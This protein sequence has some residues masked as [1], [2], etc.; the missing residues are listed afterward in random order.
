MGPHGP[1]DDMPFGVLG[2]L[3]S[4]VTAQV[5]AAALDCVCH[6]QEL[7]LSPAIQLQLRAN[8]DRGRQRQ[9]LHHWVPAALVANLE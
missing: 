1:L 7:A 9:W 2:R 6:T 8:G 3:V 4:H 5:E